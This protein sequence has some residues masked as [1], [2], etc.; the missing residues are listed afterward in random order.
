MKHVC[1]I[2][3]V[4]IIMYNNY[5]PIIKKIRLFKNTIKII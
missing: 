3:F 4:P 1:G 5:W 2:L